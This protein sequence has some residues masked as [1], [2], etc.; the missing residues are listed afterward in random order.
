MNL[1]IDR[2]HG[3]DAERNPKQRRNGH[4][5]HNA[6]ADRRAVAQ[7]DHDF[8]Q[9]ADDGHKRGGDLDAQDGYKQRHRHQTQPEADAA[10][11]EDGDEENQGNEH[12]RLAAVLEG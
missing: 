8:G 4:L 12:K 7:Q 10:L 3:E 1:G 11:D 2:A 9:H 5:G 6:E